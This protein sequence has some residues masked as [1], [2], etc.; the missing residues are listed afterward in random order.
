LSGATGGIAQALAGGLTL[1]SAFGADLPLIKP[2]LDAFKSVPAAL[3]K[4]P[5]GIVRGLKGP[6]DDWGPRSPMEGQGV[7]LKEL[8]AY[9][10]QTL[11]NVPLD[12]A[13]GLGLCRVWDRTRGRYSWVHPRYAGDY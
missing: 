1:V 3:A 6:A 8:H 5:P 11:G 4:K 7:V 13:P 9:L 2:V 10:R 12:Q